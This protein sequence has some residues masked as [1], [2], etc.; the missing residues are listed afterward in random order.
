ME[1]FDRVRFEEILEQEGLLDREHFGVS[2]LVVF[3]YRPED[4]MIHPKTRGVASELIQWV[5]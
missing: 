5:K 2:V 1:G 3:G 4:A